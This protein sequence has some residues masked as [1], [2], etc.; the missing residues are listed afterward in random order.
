MKTRIVLTIAFIFF[1]NTAAFSGVLIVNGLTHTYEG[2]SGDRVRG[3]I[4]L[5]NTSNIDQLVTFD[6]NEAI[7]SCTAFRKFTKDISHERSSLA[8]FKGNLGDKVLAPNERFVYRFSIEIPEDATLKGSYWNMVMI[9]VEKP[10]QQQKSNMVALNS[11]MQY[12]V[13]LMTNVNNIEDLDLNF[14]SIDFLPEAGLPSKNLSVNLENEN[15]FV[16]DVKL[17]LEIYDASGTKI[18]EKTT[19]RN[20]IFPGFCQEFIIDL[21]ALAAGNYQCMLIADSREEFV[22]ANVNLNI[23]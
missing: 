21:S 12:A 15:L 3:E 9:Q 20:L 5:Q 1:I 18:M 16:E 13:G 7:F 14:K 11:K 2:S 8:W 23:E 6:L 10:M 17:L 19:V 4:I 22:G